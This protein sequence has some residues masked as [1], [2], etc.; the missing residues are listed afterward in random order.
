MDLCVVVGGVEEIG[1]VDSWRV[2]P[3]PSLIS[4]WAFKHVCLFDLLNM[5]E[6]K[7]GGGLFWFHW[8]ADHRNNIRSGVFWQGWGYYGQ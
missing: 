2:L 8:L 3:H 6:V 7:G 1:R 5:F 4:Q